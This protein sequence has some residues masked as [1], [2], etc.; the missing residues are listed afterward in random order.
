MGWQPEITS[1]HDR[2]MT[3]VPPNDSSRGGVV[4]RWLIR[5][6][7]AALGVA[8]LLLA[9]TANA[10][11]QLP[12][13]ALGQVPMYRLEL[14][15]GAFFGGLLVATPLLQGVINGRLPTEITARGAKYDPEEVSE[16]LGAL[17]DRINALEDALTKT[18]GE[19]IALRAEV[20]E[21]KER[22]Q[23]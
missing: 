7:I 18:G 23:P 21:L 9:V 10:P 5:F 17:E 12:S 4:P 6:V 8:A 2:V 16:G 1:L 14:L 19:A 15:L 20:E 13:I 3:Q 11:D 22:S